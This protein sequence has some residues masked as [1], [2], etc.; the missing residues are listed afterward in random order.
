MPEENK[1][2]AESFNFQFPLLADVDR[3]VGEAYKTKRPDDHDWKDFPRRLSYLID[4]E[5]KVVK[6]YRVQDV[7][8]HPDEVL[9]DLKTLQS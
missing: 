4:P 3:T 1:A 5:G 8:A 6:V 2:F 7:N 9:E